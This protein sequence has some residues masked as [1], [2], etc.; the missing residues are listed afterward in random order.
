MSKRQFGEMI[1]GLSI[2]GRQINASV[3]NENEVRAAAGLTLVIAAVAFSYAFFAK[4][5][6]PIQMVTAFFFAELLIRVTFGLKYSPMAMLGRLLIRRQQPHWVS[7]KPKRFAWSLGVVMAL[8][9]TIITN[10]GIRGGLPLTICI[11]C[12]TLMWMEAVLGLCLGC[13][14]YAYMVRRGWV[15]K[16]DAFEICSNGVCAFEGTPVKG[17]K[18]ES[19]SNP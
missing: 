11:L 17:E 10:V 1:I 4:V 15:K 6:Q 18:R 2:D 7:A 14:I 19:I 8:A 16:D 9:M 13:E 5:Y 3:F 12:M